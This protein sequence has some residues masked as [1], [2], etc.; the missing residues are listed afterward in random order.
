MTLLTGWK[1]AEPWPRPRETKRTRPVL[2]DQRT[3]IACFFAPINAT[4][5][6][7][8]PHRSQHN[9]VQRITYAS[10]SRRHGP[11]SSV[12]AAAT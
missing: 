12:L 6:I 10:H 3:V 4:S 7:S 2:V 11:R 5:P 9:T 1:L 8:R